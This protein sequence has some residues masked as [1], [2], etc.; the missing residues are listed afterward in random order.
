MSSTVRLCGRCQV[1]V[2]QP[3]SRYFSPHF[4]KSQAQDKGD[5]PNRNAL[6]LEPANLSDFSLGELTAR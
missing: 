2:L 1:L 4:L 6:I 5:S 3:D